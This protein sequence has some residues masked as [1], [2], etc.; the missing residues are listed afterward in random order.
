MK[1]LFFCLKNCVHKKK[2]CFGSQELW[3]CPGAF[4]TQFQ[5]VKMFSR[6]LAQ[7]YCADWIELAWK[8]KADSCTWTLKPLMLWIYSNV[9]HSGLLSSRSSDMTSSK[10]LVSADC[11]PCKVQWD[12]D[13]TSRCCLVTL[14]Y[15]CRQTS[16]ESIRS[17]SALASDAEH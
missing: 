2:V 7:W 12:H 9:Y 13:I 10:S 4:E 5:N 14:R 8:V 3:F 15:H 1:N 6:S 11:T 17:R 16:W